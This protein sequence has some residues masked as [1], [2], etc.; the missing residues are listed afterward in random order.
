MNNYRIDFINWQQ[1]SF[2][3]CNRSQ[4]WGYG[5]IMSRIDYKYDKNRDLRFEFSWGNYE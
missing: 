5:A 2:S 4:N 1:R 3:D